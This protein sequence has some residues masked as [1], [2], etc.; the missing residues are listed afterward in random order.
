MIRR[1]KSTQG[2]H[3]IKPL[4]KKRKELTEKDWRGIMDIRTELALIPD[5]RVDWCKKYNLV[6]VLLLCIIAMVCGVEMVEDFAFF[7]GTHLTWLKKYLAL[8]NGTP[9][10]ETLLLITKRSPP[11]PFLRKPR[12]D[13][14]RSRRLLISGQAARSAFRR[15]SSTIMRSIT[16]ESHRIS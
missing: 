11:F 6:D 5:P 4:K 3:I 8:S 9:S 15:S 14:S 2:N 12:I 1:G 13:M 10:A 16:S 7:G